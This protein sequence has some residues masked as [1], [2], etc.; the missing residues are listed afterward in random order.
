MTEEAPGS[1]AESVASGGSSVR[2]QREHFILEFIS[3][4]DIP[5]IENKVKSDV[6][7]QA[8]IGSFSE[9]D[10]AGGR[11]F[12]VQRYGITVRTP[13]R[14]DCS[15]AVWN[16]FRDLGTN[17]P[18]D[19]VLTVELFHYYK[20]SHKNDCLLGKVDIPVRAL[21]DGEAI[22]FPLINFKVTSIPI[23]GQSYPQLYAN[24]LLFFCFN[25][26]RP[27]WKAKIPSLQLHCA[28]RS[29]TAPLRS[30]ARSS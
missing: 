7:L 10:M 1:I 23:R 22:T 3:A 4:I 9:G 5:P 24:V 20:D 6:Y 14:Y 2:T 30:T 15:A 13:I 12:Q 21:V 27:V 28:G 18:P 25:S 11:M 8:F 19:S 17:P 29:W 26:C 16:C